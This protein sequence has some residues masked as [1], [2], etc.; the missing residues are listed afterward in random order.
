M[1][2]RFDKDEAFDAL[3]RLLE[4][5]KDVFCR[6]VDHTYLDKGRAPMLRCSVGVYDIL[7][8]GCRKYNPHHS[9][10]SIETFRGM[11]VCLDPMLDGLEFYV[12]EDDGVQPPQIIHNIQD[13]PFGPIDFPLRKNPSPATWD[14]RMM[15]ELYGYDMGKTLIDRQLKGWRV[16]RFTVP[17]FRFIVKLICYA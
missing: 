8:E 15:E 4:D 14:L 6:S 16:L 12:E 3:V 17:R 10:F 5:R 13:T 1:S 2:F 11:R 9:A 7:F